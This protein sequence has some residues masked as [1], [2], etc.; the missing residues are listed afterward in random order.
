LSASSRKAVLLDRDGVINNHGD[1]V[2]HPDDMLL[3]DGAGAAIR[4]L[5]EAGLP[6][7]VIT[8][9][10]GIAMGYISERDLER[11]HARMIALLD[12][13]GAH[14]DA[15][16]FCPFHPRATVPAY[17]RDSD[18]RKPGIGMIEKA[19]DDHDLDLSASYFVGDMTGDMLAGRRAGCRTV[20][21]STGF[22]GRDGEHDVEPDLRVADLAEA[23]DVILREMRIES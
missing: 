11:I 13:E 4:R 10:G 12:A 18:L 17:R 1:Y 20:L 6:V 5:N 7:L 9:Q 23:V 8:N 15:I 19:R 2:N 14:V 21:V 22:G 16:Y 3:I